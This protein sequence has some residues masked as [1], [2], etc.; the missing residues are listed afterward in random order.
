[1]KRI[2]TLAS[3]VLL[4]FPSL[5]QTSTKTQSDSIGGVTK[6]Q[7]KK[8]SLVAIPKTL[9]IW[10]AQD[11]ARAR[12]YSEEIVLLNG[13]VALKQSIIGKQDTIISS[14]KGKLSAYV[15]LYNS[16]NESNQIYEAQIAYL[17]KDLRIKT[18]QKKFWRVTAFIM[19]MVVGGFV[20]YHWKYLHW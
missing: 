8:D 13:S 12:S 17:K 4:T 6:E 14:Y 16:C 10:M 11:V 5:S 1:M 7:L 15:S 20:H 3:L 18:A 19:P 2:I 9:A